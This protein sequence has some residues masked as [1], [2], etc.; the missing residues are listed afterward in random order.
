M[1]F[2]PEIDTLRPNQSKAVP[3]GEINYPIQ[4]GGQIVHPGDMIVADDDGIVVVPREHATGIVDK[5][6]AV[7]VRE[8][9][10]WLKLRPV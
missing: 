9:N 6:K 3:S 7:I 8:E 1:A 5:V 2:L 4:C 10:D